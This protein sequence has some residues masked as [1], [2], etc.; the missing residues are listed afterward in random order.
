MKRK[1]HCIAIA[2]CAFEVQADGFIQLTPAGL[3]GAKDGRPAGLS[4][5]M[6][7]DA[8]AA[9]VLARLK[10]RPGRM[11]I[12]YEHQ[13]LH[14]EKN[15]QK[16]PAAGWFSGAEVVWRPGEGFFVQP[17]WTAAAK[18]HIDAK[19]YRYLSPVIAYSRQTGEVLD[20]RMAALTNDPAI[21]G[22]QELELLA[23]AKY[24]T[25]QPEE[26]KMEELL[27]LFG[28]QPDASEADAVAALKA[29][30]QKRSELQAEITQKDE[31][32]AAAKAATPDDAVEAM[33]ALQAEV[34]ALKSDVRQREVAELVEAALS[35]GKLLPAQEEWATGLGKS[36]LAALKSYLETTQ[37]VAALKG[38]Q[39]KGK[40]PP[41]LG[42]DGELTDEAL[43]VCKQMGVDPEEYKKTLAEESRP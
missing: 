8:A 27:K 22:M 10:A 13:T 29:L 35:D 12:D 38:N 18:A 36:D 39:T 19:E 20:I 3:F 11:V 4:G 9:R 6:L 37:P 40:Q 17:E 2:A 14:T 30:Q 31:A 25:H 16:A 42:A 21:E 15:G 32:I 28:L 5:W 26:P 24:C 33:K 1:A 41:G 43:A 34:A 23:A 7:D